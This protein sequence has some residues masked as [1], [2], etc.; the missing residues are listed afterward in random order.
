MEGTCPYCKEDIDSEIYD[1]WAGSH[2]WT[3][4]DA[5]ECPHCGHE[6]EIE[7]RQSPVFLCK[8]K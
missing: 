7:V 2:Y 5:F 8:K 4:E 3:H 1:C 6:I